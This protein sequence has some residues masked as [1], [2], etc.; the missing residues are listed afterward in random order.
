MLADQQL[1]YYL[2]NQHPPILTE[3]SEVQSPLPH[4]SARRSGCGAKKPGWP[5]R[6]TVFSDLSDCSFG[7]LRKRARTYYEF[8]VRLFVLFEV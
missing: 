3:S 2:L 7:P 4:Q 8:E 5:E 6:N 1:F